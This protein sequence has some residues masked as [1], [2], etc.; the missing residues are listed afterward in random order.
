[1]PVLENDFFE[2]LL[3]DLLLNQHVHVFHAGSRI[4]RTRTPRNLLASNALQRLRVLHGD[5][6]SVDFPGLHGPISPLHL[7]DRHL[8]LTVWAQPPKITSLAHVDQFLGQASCHGVRQRHRVLSLIGRI[9]E[10]DTLVTSSDVRIILA[11]LHAAC[12]VGALPVGADH[13]LAVLVVQSLSVNAAQVDNERV[14]SQ[15]ANQQPQ[16]LLELG[17]LCFLPRL[18]PP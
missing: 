6:N 13:N 4:F 2:C 7:F 15:K 10:H 1:V 3:H 9:P 16:R 12:N 14:N 11:D 18:L 8:C 17:P 5:Y